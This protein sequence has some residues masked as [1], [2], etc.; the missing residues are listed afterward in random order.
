VLVEKTAPS[1]FLQCQ[2]FI[3]PP[4]VLDVESGNE[5]SGDTALQ[6]LQGEEMGM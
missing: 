2:L 5:L 3:Q 4:E 1:N 6:A